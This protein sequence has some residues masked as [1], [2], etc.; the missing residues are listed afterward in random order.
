MYMFWIMALVFIVF[1]FI[2]AFFVF[3]NITPAIF[4][5]LFFSVAACLPAFMNTYGHNML[6]L[7]LFVLAVTG[8]LIAGLQVLGIVSIGP[9]GSVLIN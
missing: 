2:G 4:Q 5:L 9:T 1:I 8:L 3:M 6:V 7:G